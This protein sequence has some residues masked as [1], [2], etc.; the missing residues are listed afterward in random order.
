MKE[1]ALQFDCEGEKLLGILHRPGPGG[2]RTGVVVVVGG[3]Q[4]RVGSHRQFVLMAR[5][6]AAAGFCVLRFDYRGMGDSGGSKRTFEAVDADIRAAVDALQ[7]AEPA[8]DD[9]VLFG[10]CDA[11]SAVLLYCCSDPRIGGLILANPW[12]RSDATAA[13]TVVRHYYGQRL[14][15]RSFWSKFFSGRFHVGTAIKGFV[16]SLRAAGGKGPSGDDSPRFVQRMRAGLEGFRGRV[17]L[18]LSDNDLTA[19][20]F[21]GVCEKSAGWKS[22]L[23]SSRVDRKVVAN[24]DHTFSSAAAMGAVGAAIVEWIGRSR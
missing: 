10:L 11:A 15:Q 1:S 16:A 9:I 12:V 23:T 22:A 13:R 20:E 4:Y 24:A 8:L 3:P 6:L 2:L 18:L 17:L 21:E 19:R 14:L 7:T 5:Q